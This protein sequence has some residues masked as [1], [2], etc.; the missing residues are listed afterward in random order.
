MNTSTIQIERKRVTRRRGTTAPNVVIR[1]ACDRDGIVL[2]H[3]VAS[4]DGTN[5]GIVA[6]ARRAT[7][8]MFD[9]FADVSNV[10]SRIIAT[11]ASGRPRW[12]VSPN[13]QIVEELAVA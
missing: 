2:G 5:E 9:A 12:S 10:S 6:A 8:R 7:Q 3:L 1:E 13:F 4:H 11:D